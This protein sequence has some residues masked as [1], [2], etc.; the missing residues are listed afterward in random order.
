MRCLESSGQLMFSIRSRS[1]DNSFN[2]VY[3][4]MLQSENNCSFQNLQNYVYK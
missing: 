4:Y 1:T 3:K 2:V